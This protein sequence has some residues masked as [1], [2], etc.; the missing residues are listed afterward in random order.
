[1]SFTNR[2]TQMM[3]RLSA[4]Y[5]TCNL[6]N[7]SFMIGYLLMKRIRAVYACGDMQQ[8]DL[9]LNTICIRVVVVL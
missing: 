5:Y 1:M 8:L 3:W 9:N 6:S 7:M 4:S 2:T